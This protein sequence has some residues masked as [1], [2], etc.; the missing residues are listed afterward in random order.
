M[1]Q[2]SVLDINGKEVDKIELDPLIFDG[3]VNNEL[4]HQ[5]VVTYLAN[6]RKGLASAKTRGEVSGGGR[7]PW[8]QK[9][10][11]RARVGSI[12]S[13]LWKGGGVTFGPKPHSFNKILPRKMRIL[14]FKNALNAKLN[15]NQIT[16]LDKLEIQ[17]HKTKEMNGIVKNL[18]LNGGRVKFIVETVDSKVKLS[19]RNLAKVSVM[20]AKDIA[21]Y[22]VMDCKRLI[23]TK[24]ALKIMEDRIRQVIK[25]EVSRG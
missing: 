14:A 21:T 17:S 15:D 16:I 25:P 1:R 6:Q 2:V 24:N 7:K 20:A 4:I 13:P 10:T 22:E 5:A 9:G 3:K 12:R 8:R 18:N 11:G 19:S 23:L